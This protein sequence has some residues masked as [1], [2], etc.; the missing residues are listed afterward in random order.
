M[1]K[2]RYNEIGCKLFERHFLKEITAEKLLRLR[3]N[4]IKKKVGHFVAENSSLSREEVLGFFKWFINKIC[5]KMKVVNEELQE[6]SF[7]K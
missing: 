3:E 2:E 1:D 4:D 6:I 7:Q 5:T